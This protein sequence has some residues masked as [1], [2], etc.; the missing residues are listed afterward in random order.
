MHIKMLSRED[1]SYNVSPKQAIKAVPFSS[2]QR[3]L[4]IHKP[5][6]GAKRR[7]T[8]PPPGR[9]DS[10]RRCSACFA[11]PAVAAGAK[12]S[13]ACTPVVAGGGMD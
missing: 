6:I 3:G 10:P 4:C 12:G 1:V 9:F 11:A 13:V 7:S 8:T 5:N 2:A